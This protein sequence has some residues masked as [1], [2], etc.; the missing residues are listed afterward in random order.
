[1]TYLIIGLLFLKMGKKFLLSLNE[2]SCIEI[3]ALVSEVLRVCFGEGQVL[4]FK[5]Y[6]IM[7]NLNFGR[8]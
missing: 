3:I 8:L 6:L 7:L 4:N 2:F 1:M 5:M